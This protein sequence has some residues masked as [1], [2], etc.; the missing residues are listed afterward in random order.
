MLNS[1]HTTVATPRK[2]PGRLAPHSGPETASTLTQVS[3]SAGPA[4][5]I[6]STAGANTRSA[7]AAAERAASGPAP[8][9]RQG[10]L[11]RRER[12]HL[13]SVD[14]AGREAS[15]LGGM[16]GVLLGGE[17]AA[18]HLADVASEGLHH[19]LSQVG[20]ALHELGTEPVV[21]PE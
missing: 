10:R 2:W 8:H 4:G 11:R 5:Y 1:L 20:V 21:H 13:V 19:L 17:G 18:P 14:E 3:C 15:R 7:P 12:G 16:E 9:H 6:S